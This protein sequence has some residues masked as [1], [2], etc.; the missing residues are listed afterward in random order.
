MENESTSADLS[1]DDDE[2]FYIGSGD[3]VRS[4]RENSDPR[5]CIVT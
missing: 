2:A 1:S 3:A 5:E 4:R